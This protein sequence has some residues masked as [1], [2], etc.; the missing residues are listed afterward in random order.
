MLLCLKGNMNRGFVIGSMKVST[1]VIL[2]LGGGAG[3][4]S[5]FTH[6]IVTLASFT[7]IIGAPG[8][9]VCLIQ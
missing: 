8:S 3:R 9:H 4:G 7:G 2:F 5:C 1:K 6:H